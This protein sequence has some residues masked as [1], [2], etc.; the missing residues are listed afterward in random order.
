MLHGREPFE[1]SVAP[2]GSQGRTVQVVGFDTYGLD[3]EGDGRGCE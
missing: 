1:V 2:V 3:R